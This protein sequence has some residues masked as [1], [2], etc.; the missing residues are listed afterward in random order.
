MYCGWR[1]P[2]HPEFNSITFV[3]HTR[4]HIRSSIAHFAPT[5][6]HLIRSPHSFT[7]FVH[8]IRSPHP[9]TTFVHHI[10]SPHLFTTFDHHI[11][12]PQ[13]PLAQFVS[14]L[15]NFAAQFGHIRSP[16]YPL[17]NFAFRFFYWFHMAAVVEQYESD[18]EQ[19][20]SPEVAR[21][22]KR[23]RAR[24]WEHDQ[25]FASPESAIAFI[26]SEGT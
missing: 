4:H 13:S 24:S 23:K 3:D 25:S 22:R 16:L 1:Q 14:T 5:F 26:Q 9:F 17:A 18:D 11:R 21:T 20:F 12:S 8:L 15:S 6:H 19:N 2:I 10:R 7:T